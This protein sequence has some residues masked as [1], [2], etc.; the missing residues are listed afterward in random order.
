MKKKEINLSIA[1]FLFI[2]TFSFSSAGSD[3]SKMNL[4]GKVKTIV[5]F[6]FEAKKKADQVIKGNLTNV[7]AEDDNYSAF[8]SL[9]K[10]TEQASFAKERVLLHRKALKYDRN[11]SLIE[12]LTFNP[13]SS[14]L[15]KVTYTRDPNHR[16]I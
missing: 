11:D 15:E 10:L 14:L 16:A 8:D 3:L 6:E 5:T 12:I 1:T 9:G 4:D 7:A 13:D 2:I